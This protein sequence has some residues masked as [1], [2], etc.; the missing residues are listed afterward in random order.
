MVRVAHMTRG[1]SPAGCRGARSDMLE[2]MMDDEDEVR[3]M[4]LSSRPLREERRRQ[5][6]IDR[7]ERGRERCI[8]SLFHCAWKRQRCF[9]NDA[10]R[11]PLRLGAL[12][13]HMCVQ[14]RKP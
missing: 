2:E 4:N 5:R 3:E 1:L 9:P 14:C 10:S 12:P 13:I 8:L 11:H 7:I 6:E